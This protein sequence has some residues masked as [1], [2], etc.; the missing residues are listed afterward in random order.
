MGVGVCVQAGRADD[1]GSLAQRGDWGGS[2]GGGVGKTLGVGLA[3][4]L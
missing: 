2:R 3:F 4:P 1:R